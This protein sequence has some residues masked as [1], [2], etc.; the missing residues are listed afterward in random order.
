VPSAVRAIEA[1]DA[2]QASFEHLYGVLEG[3][4]DDENW[5]IADN[6]AFLDRRAA[7]RDTRRQ[8]RA[9]FRR[10]LDTQDDRRCRA[11][12][13]HLAE[14]NVAQVP[15]LAAQRGVFRLRDPDA[16]SDPRL[17]Y[18]RPEARAR[19]QAGSYDET[20]DFGPAD[21]ELRKRRYDRLREVV[22]M[23]NEEG[24]LLLA[25]SDF[26]PTIA[27]TFP[28]FSLHEELALMV[29]AGLT[30]AEA[31]RTATWNPAVYLAAIDT[32]GTI[33]PGRVADLVLLDADPLS[34]IRALDRIRGV[35]LRGRWL[36]AATL[37]SW[38]DSVATAYRE[39]E[40]SLAALPDGAER[41]WAAEGPGARL[42]AVFLLDPR[43]LDGL[44]PTWLAPLTAEEAVTEDPAIEALLRSRPELRRWIVSGLEIARSDSVFFDGGAP[45]RS[46]SARWWIAARRPPAEPPA[47]LAPDV[48]TRFL[49]AEWGTG[50]G[51]GDVTAHRYR[52]G[53]WAFGVQA[54]GLNLTAVCTPG[55]AG[56]PFSGS[57]DGTVWWWGPGRAPD[58]TLVTTGAGQVAR[59]C[60]LQMS[61]DGVHALASAL[62]GAAWARGSLL[63]T[64]LVEGGRTRGA[65]YSVD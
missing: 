23:M 18:V 15:T 48:A 53:T 62:H 42:R 2:G 22:R 27:F 5:L 3:C 58:R 21:W 26:H 46:T 38:K 57:P 36:P 14:R 52:S 13:H 65:A 28:G 64:R 29:D 33:E 31:L 7:G 54:P 44:A 37:E 51:P 19:W 63:G 59:E 10:L 6:L 11:L 55:G 9:W 30:P 60:D 34:D 56:A 45:R 32:T 49:L 61:A 24:I 50:G 8:D 16:A 39:A 17:R 1:A 41:V 25:G 20:R 35:A 43:R 4:S 12:L 40:P 47:P